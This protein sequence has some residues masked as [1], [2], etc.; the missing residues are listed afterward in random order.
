MCVVNT[1]QALIYVYFDDEPA[2]SLRCAILGT[3][4]SFDTMTAKPSAAER[5]PTSCAFSGAVM[6]FCNNACVTRRN[7]FPP[8]GSY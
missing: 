1:G 6:R 4:K 5:V 8:H 7:R 3:D 2:A